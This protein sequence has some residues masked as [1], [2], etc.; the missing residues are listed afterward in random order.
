MSRTP[1][2]R[3]L[4]AVS[5]SAGALLAVGAAFARRPE[6]V[7]AL[8]PRLDSALAS[9]PPG[10]ILLIA[11]LVLVFFASTLGLAGRLRATRPDPLV[12]STDSSAA[13]RRKSTARTRPT[14]GGSFDRYVDRATA[15]DDG[16]RDVRTSA[17]EALVG[18]LRRTAATTYATRVGVGD[19]RALAAI[20]EGTWTDDPRAAAF[21]AGESGPSTPL[22]CWLFD[23]ARGVDP[24]EASLEATID[25]LE[26]LQSQPTRPSESPGRATLTARA[27]E[28]GVKST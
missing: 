21:L 8:A 9:L 24:F 19:E 11:T 20:E 27:T 3:G 14:V 12:D 4:L 13:E 28:P 15:S 18:S 6:F 10:T 22:R 2:R 26:A 25:E 16:A 5:L 1:S 23:L 7:V 17:R